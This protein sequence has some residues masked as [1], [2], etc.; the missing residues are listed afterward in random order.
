[1]RNKILIVG[2]HGAVGS[3]ILKELLQKGVLAEQLIIA[4]RSEDKMQRFLKNENLK[5]ETITLDIHRPVSV[6]LLEEVKLVIM[7]IDQNETRFV[8]QL[9]DLNI[10]YVDITANSDFI[11]LVNQLPQTNE[12]SIVTSVGLAPGLTNLATS[13]YIQKKQP[14]QVVIDVLLGAG[15]SHGEAAV[16]WMFD[17]INQPYHIKQ[18]SEPIKNFTLKRK[19]NFTPK[20]TNRMTYNFNFSDQHILNDQYPNIPITTYLGFDINLVSNSLHWLNKRNLLGK[21]EKEKSISFLKKVMSKELIGRDD[22]AIHVSNGK[23]EDKG[24]SLYGRNEK[25]VTGK[26]AAYVSYRVF[27]ASQKVGISS[28]EAVCTLEELL[29]G[30]KIESIGLA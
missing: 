5:I 24:I 30:V 26:I 23:E 4:G 17:Q 16:H 28:I 14:S 13:Y 12:A 10:D 2:G 18:A 21:L 9:I 27:T 15:E 7:C 1:M 8:S 11:K 6:K 29:H 22:F 19:V 20:L 25:E 3:I